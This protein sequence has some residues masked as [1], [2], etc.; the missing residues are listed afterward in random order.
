MVCKW[1]F[2]D[3]MTKP[4]CWI[5]GVKDGFD[6]VTL[7]QEKQNVMNLDKIQESENS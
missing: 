2:E 7:E 1:E 5:V 4:P 6:D 3:S